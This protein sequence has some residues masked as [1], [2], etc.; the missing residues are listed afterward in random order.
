[1]I[2]YASQDVFFLE[3]TYEAM[4]A[5]VSGNMFNSADIS[6]FVSA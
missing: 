6:E 4:K 5:I 3:E 1:M 2:D